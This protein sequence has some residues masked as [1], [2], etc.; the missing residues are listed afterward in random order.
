MCPYFLPYISHISSIFVI[1]EKPSFFL[2]I[3]IKKHLRIF[4]ADPG[5]PYNPTPPL[6]LGCY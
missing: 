2:H 5:P 3:E 6:A 4:M 1:N